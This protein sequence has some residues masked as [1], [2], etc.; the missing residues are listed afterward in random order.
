MNQLHFILRGLFSGALMLLVSLQVNAGAI[1]QWTDAQGGTW[2]SDAPP[3]Q[4]AG[5]T[6]DVQEIGLRTKIPG[7][8][9]EYEQQPYSIM[10]QVE[11]FQRQAEK[12]QRMRLERLAVSQAIKQAEQK[13]ASSAAGKSV[14]AIVPIVQFPLASGGL[15]RPHIAH[16]VNP[17]PVQ[18]PA[19]QPVHHASS[20]LSAPPSNAGYL[21][22]L[23]LGGSS[24]FAH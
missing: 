12:R 19:H 2:F 16:G 7:L 5:Y 23:S 10:K 6:A 24:H 13:D 14:P 8:V 17:Q 18:Q 11:F 15:H 9:A 1:Y 21:F 4:Q 22:N 3:K 20:S